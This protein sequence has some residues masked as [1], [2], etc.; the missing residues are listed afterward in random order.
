MLWIDASV[1]LPKK[2]HPRV[3]AGWACSRDDNRIGLFVARLVV[4]LWSGWRRPTAG[5]S[6]CNCLPMCPVQAVLRF[7]DV[8][9]HGG[10]TATE[11]ST[12][13]W[14]VSTPGA[15]LLVV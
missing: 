12:S 6:G 9:D 5:R 8:R 4:W 10:A 14:P 3:L 15:K 11:D 1:D 7:A 2:V 13:N